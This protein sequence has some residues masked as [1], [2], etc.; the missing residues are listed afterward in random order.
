MLALQP[1]DLMRQFMG[2]AVRQ[3]QRNSHAAVNPHRGSVVSLFTFYQAAD[4]RARHAD[5]PDAALDRARQA[6]L[7]PAD[8]RQTDLTPTRRQFLDTDFPAGVAEGVVDAPLLRLR[9]TAEPLPRAMVGIIR[10]FEDALQRGDM[11]VADEIELCT[12]VR[13]FA[14]LRNAGECV[15]GAFLVKSPVVPALLQRQVPDEA[16]NAGEL[17]HQSCL[18][19]RGAQRVCVPA[20]AVSH[21]PV[22]GGSTC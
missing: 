6:E 8:L 20:P 17:R 2:T 15:A 21:I 14:G 10:R 22:Y 7:D 4:G 3:H 9:I 12:E 11:H 19:F 18:L 16:A 1:L 5:L 13:E